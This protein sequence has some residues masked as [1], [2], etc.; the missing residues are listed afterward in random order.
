M[1]LGWYLKLVGWLFGLLG[2]HFST[3]A[4]LRAEKQEAVAPRPSTLG[5]WATALGL[6]PD[7]AA[8][9][10]AAAPVAA[11]QWELVGP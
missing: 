11:P 8:V 7:D 3:P 1:L 6:S 9:R 2:I 10:K 4:F 5:R